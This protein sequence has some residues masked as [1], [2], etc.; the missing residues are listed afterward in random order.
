MDKI[1]KNQAKKGLFNSNTRLSGHA[2]LNTGNFG[3]LEIRYDH[4][5]IFVE[6]SHTQNCKH[7]NFL[8]GTTYQTVQ[9]MGGQLSKMGQA[10]IL[11]T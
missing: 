10:N 2:H 1:T 6:K 3:I 11:G 4:N 7:L 8:D 9:S 5:S